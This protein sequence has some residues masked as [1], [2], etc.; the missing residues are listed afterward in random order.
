[1]QTARTKC[2]GGRHPV[3]KEA[4][5]FDLPSNRL[6][7]VYTELSFTVRRRNLVRADEVL[8]QVTLSSE[9]L[10]RWKKSQSLAGTLDEAFRYPGKVITQTHFIAKL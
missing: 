10:L 1:M 4:F 9:M 7:S 5:S 2:Y 8:G 6:V 3:Y